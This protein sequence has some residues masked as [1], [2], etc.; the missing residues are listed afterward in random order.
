MIRDAE[1]TAVSGDRVRDQ[2]GRTSVEGRPPA[3]STRR[4]EMEMFWIILVVGVIG[5]LT[6]LYFVN[7]WVTVV[8]GA[9]FL[10][11]Y[12][13]IGGFPRYLADSM[14]QKE[15]LE[16]IDEIKIQDSR[17]HTRPGS[18]SGPTRSRGASSPP[19]T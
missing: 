15:R 12:A 13:V 5:V 16:A 7:G 2:V 11:V 14:R 9:I 1:G 10:F 3:E 18:D 19:P 17:L 4:P 6:A 8:A